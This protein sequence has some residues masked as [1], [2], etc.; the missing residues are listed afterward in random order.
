MIFPFIIW[1]THFGTLSFPRLDRLGQAELMG[2]LMEGCV[3]LSLWFSIFYNFLM[4]QS[5]PLCK[6]Q[7][8]AQ[9]WRFVFPLA[10]NQERPK[11]PEP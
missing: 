5:W 8:A 4:V 1:G 9:H 2:D 6:P 11:Q 7:F 3:T 10:T